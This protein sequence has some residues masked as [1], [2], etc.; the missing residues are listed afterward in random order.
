MVFAE[1]YDTTKKQ[2]GKDAAAGYVYG[3]DLLSATDNT[4]VQTTTSRTAFAGPLGMGGEKY[5]NWGN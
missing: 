5:D 1:E 2:L 4:G 3:L